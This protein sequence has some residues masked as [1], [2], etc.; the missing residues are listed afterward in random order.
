MKHIKMIRINPVAQDHFDEWIEKDGA[1]SDGITHIASPNSIQNLLEIIESIKPKRVIEFGGGIGTIDHLLMKHTIC[2]LDICE[3]NEFCIEQL[4]KNLDG[5]ESRYKLYTNKEELE[6][7]YVH[8]DLVIVDG[9][10][11]HLFKKFVK[12]TH[13]KNIFY[14]GNRIPAQREFLKCLRSKY[15]VKYFRFEQNI[16]NYTS[17]YF[18]RCTKNYFFVVRWL[19]YFCNI[20]SLH[21]IEVK[22]RGLK[23]YIWILLRRVKNKV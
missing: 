1:I 14:E 3:E 9:H 13:I 18:M 23:K 4:K 7:T 21:K 17:G 2:T 8:Y 15:T 10:W 16:N 5:Y 20:L 11:N 22:R 19:N 6:H 12:N